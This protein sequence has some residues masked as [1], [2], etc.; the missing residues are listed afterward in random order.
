MLR[1]LPLSAQALDLTQRLIADLKLTET[2][3]ELLDA[4]TTAR[5]AETSPLPDLNEPIRRIEFEDISFRYG[6]ET[7]EVLNHFNCSFTAGR[8]Y[9]IAGPSG[10]GKST[11]IDDAAQIFQS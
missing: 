3:T 7:P 6:S 10:S 5:T 11:I 2:V 1:L 9:A 4:V 8:T